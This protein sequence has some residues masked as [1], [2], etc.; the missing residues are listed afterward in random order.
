MNKFQDVH[1]SSVE[2]FLDYLPENEKGITLFLRKLIFDNIPNC[3]E[4]LAYNVPFYYLKSRICYIWPA[5][6]PWGKI[7]KEG[8]QFGFCEGHLLSNELNY[9]EKGNRKQ[10][11]IKTFYKIPDIDTA[12]LKVYL[13]EA[14]DVN[15]AK[16]KMRIIR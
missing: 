8:V 2:D 9:L 3:V 1:F 13:Q 4:K 14:A 11:F 6:V 16:K 5:S 7:K 12:I 15:R 10:V